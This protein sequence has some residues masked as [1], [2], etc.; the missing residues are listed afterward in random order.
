MIK[1]KF[2]EAENKRNL[3]T[4]HGNAYSAKGPEFREKAD[5]TG[6]VD[7]AKTLLQVRKVFTIG[8][9]KA[10]ETGED[11]EIIVKAYRSN[12]KKLGYPAKGYKGMPLDAKITLVLEIPADMSRYEDVAYVTVRGEDETLSFSA[13]AAAAVEAF[14]HGADTFVITGEGAKK[15]LEAG[16][17]GLMLGGSGTFITNDGGGSAAGAVIAPGIGYAKSW[18][19]YEFEP[20]I[21]GFGLKTK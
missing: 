9:L 17:W 18:S 20:W 1:Q 13:I 7:D 4:G 6:N 3:P 11:L 10:I 2:V 16:G 21:Q 15:M 8:M 19:G 14:R 5:R 12:M